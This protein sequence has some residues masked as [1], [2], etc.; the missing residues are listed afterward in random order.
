[1]PTP[2]WTCRVHLPPPGR[3][4]GPGQPGWKVTR[5]VLSAAGAAACA[6]MIP[7]GAHGLWLASLLLVVATRSFSAPFVPLG[8][9]L[10]AA[11]LADAP[12]AAAGQLAR[13]VVYGAAAGYAVAAALGTR[14]L[15]PV[16]AFDP[17]RDGRSIA[18]PAGPVALVA[19]GWLVFALARGVLL[20]DAGGAAPVVAALFLA[21][22]VLLAVL[23]VVGLVS[24]RGHGACPM[25]FR[26]ADGG[27]GASDSQFAAAAA[28]ALA[29]LVAPHLAWAF[30][31]RAS[32]AW[33]VIG[34]IIA[35][36][37]EAIAWVA[38]WYGG[39]VWFRYGDDSRDSQSRD[40]FRDSQSRVTWAHFAAVC[41]TIH[42]GS[43]VVFLVAAAFASPGW[44]GDVL[45]GGMAAL[46]AGAAPL[47]WMRLARGHLAA[48]G[49]VLLHRAH[50]EPERR[51]APAV[52]DAD[53][54]RRMDQLTNP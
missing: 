3:P 54:R 17:V 12:D 35:V 53:R 33:F 48:R 29:V 38:V 30:A 52:S 32:T 45:L 10:A 4:G 39:H 1:M 37:A 18:H 13:A 5:G 43:A 2:R 21:A 49:S 15:I 36:C 42:L 24:A 7:P 19:S 23:A 6:A 40:F 14:V 34:G 11:W 9:V 50:T 20:A 25:V 16:H 31:A 28:A 51:R 41:A 47:M 44:A 26:Y 22:A 46:V 8:A 27:V